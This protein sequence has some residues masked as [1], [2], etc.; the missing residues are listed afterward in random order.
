M[1]SASLTSPPSPAQHRDIRAAGQ[2][3]KR[4][5]DHSAKWL[6]GKRPL[7][8]IRDLHVNLAPSGDEERWTKDSTP[9]Q[10]KVR[11]RKQ[12]SQA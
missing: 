1:S 12:F 5:K 11:P 3:F 4:D 10:G 7:P 2:P 9:Q 8:G 6:D